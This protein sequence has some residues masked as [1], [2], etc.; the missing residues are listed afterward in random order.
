MSKRGGRVPRPPNPKRGEW[1]LRF[2]K[3]AAGDNWNQASNQWGTNC[4]VAW[5]EL[6]KDPRRVTSRQHQLEAGFAFIERDGKRLEHWQYELTGGARIHYSIDDERR[7]VWFEAV[8]LG[9]PK[10]TEG[11]K[12]RRR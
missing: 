6:T 5:D 7:I 8:H 10:H 9:H 11:K 12:G 2:V 4:S 1:D 3:K